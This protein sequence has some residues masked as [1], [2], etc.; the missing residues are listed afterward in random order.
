MLDMRS[1]DEVLSTMDARGLRELQAC[2]V[3]QF[4]VQNT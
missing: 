3:V 1:V 4:E 2:G